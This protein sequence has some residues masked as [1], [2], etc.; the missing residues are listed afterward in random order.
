MGWFDSLKNELIDIIEWLD[1]SNDTLVHRFE[2]HDN[3]IKNG[4]QLIVRESQAAVFVDQGE[5]ADVFTP[6]RH[7]LST[8]NLPILS[9]L[10]GWKYGFDSP[11]KSEVYF[12]STKRMIDLGWGTPNPVMMRDQDFGVVRA[13]AFG[14]FSIRIVEPKKFLSEVAGTN[15]GYK[16]EDIQDFL[17]SI[18]V[19][20]FSD[21]LAEAKIPVLDVAAKYDELSAVCNEKLKAKFNEF[22][23][24]LLDFVIENIS[25]PEEVE[26]M[27][28]KRT[29]MGAVGENNFNS[30]QMGKSLEDAANN[31]GAGVSDAV[32]MGL[33]FGMANNLMNNQQ[34]QNSSNGGSTPPPFNEK[35]YF[36]ILNGSQNGPYPVS[37]I[38]EYIKQGNVNRDTM[39]WAEGMANWDQAGKIGEFSSDFGAM[40]PPPPPMS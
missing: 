6:G 29:S 24:D 27:I 8:S 20:G 33:G 28:D 17:R 10:K 22:G 23:L 26:R 12:V 18:I 7:E 37:Q 25:L 19:S 2:R 35:K 13:R 36:V 16:T 34:Y 11:F 15:S 9:T 5:Y 31:P 30:F 3:E 1:D 32:G 14:N 4:A 40:P 38:K 21:A 39:V